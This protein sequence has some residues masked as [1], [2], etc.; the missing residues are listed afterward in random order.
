MD[1]TSRSVYPTGSTKITRA[2]K[3]GNMPPRP[4]DYAP[5][6]IFTETQ[7][8]KRNC[9]ERNPFHEQG[10]QEDRYQDMSKLTNSTGILSHSY[11]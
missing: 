3:P 7:Q 4:C 5:M 9:E 1:G 10:P 6:L 8:M 11:Q 2:L